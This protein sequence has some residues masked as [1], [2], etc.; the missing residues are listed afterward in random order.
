MCICINCK[1][2]YNCSTYYLIEKQHGKSHLNNYPLF[3]AH[4]PIINVN[5]IINNQQIKIDWDVVNCL[6]FVEDPGKWLY[7]YKFVN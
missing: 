7:Y 5:I 6:S 2:I 3:I 1:H 4:D